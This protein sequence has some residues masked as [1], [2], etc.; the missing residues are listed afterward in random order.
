M[1]D[2]KDTRY[3]FQCQSFQQYECPNKA[4][5]DD[6]EIIKCR[7]DGCLGVNCNVCLYWDQHKILRG[8]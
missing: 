4:F 7:C 5:C 8:K 6:H 1:K 3:P 2:R